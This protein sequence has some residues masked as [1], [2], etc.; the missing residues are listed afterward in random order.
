MDTAAF[1]EAVE[2]ETLR[3]ERVRV[4]LLAGILALA[5]GALLIILTFAPEIPQRLFEGRFRP[6]LIAGFLAGAIA[7]E[8]AARAGLSWLIARERNLPWPARY[9]HAL[10]ETSLPSLAMVYGAVHLGDPSVALAAPPAFAYFVFI[11]LSVLRLDFKLGVFTGAVAA[12][13]YGALALLLLPDAPR[14]ADPRLIAPPLHIAKVALLL[15]S[16]LVAGFVARELRR[17]ISDAFRTALE[18]ERV[19]DLFGKHVSPAVVDKLLAQPADLGEVRHVCVMFFDIRDFTTFAESKSPG[20]VVEYLN[21]LFTPLIDIVNAH[22]G[23]IN[24]FLG[25]GFMAVFGAPI[26]DG[27]DSRN[28]VEAGMEMVARVRELCAAG[29]LPPTRVGIGLHSGEAVTGSV[30]SPA[31]K[32]YTIIGDVV[33]LAS[34]IEGMNKQFGTQLLASSEVITSAGLDGAVPR[35]E[36]QVKGRAA[37]VQ[38]YQLS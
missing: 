22:H 8:L 38:L 36:V 1:E 7:Y 24:K 25:D 34:R 15:V 13:E 21:T 29:R 9:G 27:K 28:A 14:T 20:A 31:R 32:E 26:S 23:I 3:S 2:R 16:G 33:N 11:L 4:T 19:I 12:A 37:P 10:I 5:L 6:G 30:G 35:G 18:R 17:R